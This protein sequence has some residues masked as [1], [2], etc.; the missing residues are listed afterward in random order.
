MSGA[1]A[2][3]PDLSME[4]VALIV[5][6]SFVMLMICIC[7]SAKLESFQNQVSSLKIFGILCSH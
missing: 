6:Q 2:W 4:I 7:I 3:F 1:S 5:W